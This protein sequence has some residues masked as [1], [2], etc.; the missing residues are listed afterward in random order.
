MGCARAFG[1]LITMRDDPLDAPIKP[2]EANDYH[3]KALAKA[4]ADLVKYE[5]MSIDDW[6]AK[7]DEDYAKSLDSYQQRAA[8]REASRHRYAVMLVK[9][10]AFKSP[11]PDHDKYAKFLVSQLE[12][13]IARDCSDEY[14]TTPTKQ[15]AAQCR[16]AS[17]KRAKEDIRYH[18]KKH[19]EEVE[20]T[21][22]RDAWVESLRDALAQP[23]TT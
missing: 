8:D 13:S 2:F 4:R 20:R 19:A 12:E 21:N 9:A 15:T 1:A 7:A 14:D 23:V 3:Q 18:Q 11:T 22:L 16:H 5:R 6:G 10:R 17:L